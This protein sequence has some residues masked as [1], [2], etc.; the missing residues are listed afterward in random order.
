ML[1][2]LAKNKNSGL[3]PGGILAT[4]IQ[5]AATTEMKVNAL[6]LLAEA[7]QELTLAPFNQAQIESN[8]AE[9]QLVLDLLDELNAD[10]MLGA[11]T[12]VLQNGSQRER[13]A[14]F[15]TLEDMHMIAPVWEAAL[16]VLNDPDPQIRMRA[17]ELLTYG[18]QQAATDHLLAALSD[19]NPDV[20]DLAEKLLTGLEETHS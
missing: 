16:T 8:F 12:G 6:R 7:S 2:T 17:M 10:A 20:S 1:A 9:A 19:P 11:V 13:L 18:D 5:T 14:A 15:S 4:L 3:G